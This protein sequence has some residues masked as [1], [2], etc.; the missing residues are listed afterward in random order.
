M[1]SRESWVFKEQQE[2]QVLRVFKDLQEVEVEV[3]V[4]MELQELRGLLDLKD[5]QDLLELMELMEVR[6]LRGLLVVEEVVEF[7]GLLEEE[8]IIWNLQHQ[9][10]FFQIIMVQAI[11]LLMVII[12]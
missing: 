9:G 1:V 11:L 8:S 4:Q 6:D 3:E 12:N 7:L 2:L 5:S 10:Y